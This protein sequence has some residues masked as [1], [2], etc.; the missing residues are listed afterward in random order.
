[1]RPFR[2]EAPA[3]PL[4]DLDDL[5][6]HLRFD[7]PDQ[8]D[9]ITALEAVAVDHLDGYSGRLG[10]CI[11]R[12][13][14]AFPLIGQ[15]HVVPLPFPDCREFKIE[16]FDGST[17]WTDA[18]G[19]VVPC[20]LDTVLLEDMP[21]DWSGLHLT[22]YAGAENTAEVKE[23]I[24][25]AVKLMVSHWFKNTSAVTTDETARELPMGVQTLLSPLINVMG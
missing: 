3:S 19:T 9:L 2:V 24:K 12:Q 13:K 8:D 23:A 22:C 14:W 10:R 20:P 16:H 11:L 25:H 15:P 7:G 17:T 4:V 21:D 6:A 1:M 5:K 18:E